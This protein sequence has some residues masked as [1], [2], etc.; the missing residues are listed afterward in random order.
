M[1]MSKEEFVRRASKDMAKKKR[2]REKLE[3][4]SRSYKFNVLGK[5]RAKLMKKKFYR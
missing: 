3:Y 2:K 4:D 1:K 5:A